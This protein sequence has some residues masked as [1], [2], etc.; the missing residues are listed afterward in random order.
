MDNTTQL[1]ETIL[2]A[3]AKNKGGH[4]YPVNIPPNTT[5]QHLIAALGKLEL[6]GTTNSNDEGVA[7]IFTI[8]ELGKHFASSG[9][10]NEKEKR[11]KISL[12]RHNQ[13]MAAANKNNRLIQWSI[14]AT[15]LIGML[16]MLFSFLVK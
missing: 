5:S 16:S 13:Q 8:N 9:A 3:A 2:F 1:A 7:P 4:C 14:V 11:E 10:W 12:E 15:V 6:Y